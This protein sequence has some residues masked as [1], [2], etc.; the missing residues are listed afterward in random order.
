[1]DRIFAPVM[2]HRVGSNAFDNGKV[3]P[4]GDKLC[5]LASLK[6]RPL[7][8]ALQADRDTGRAGAATFT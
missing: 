7:D 5:K 4:E 1:M 6:S 2:F 3:S 8:T